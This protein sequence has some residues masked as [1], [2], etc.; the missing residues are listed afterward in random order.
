MHCSAQNKHTNMFSATQQVPEQRDT[1]ERS[2]SSF[3]A[4]QTRRLGRRQS[5]PL[6]SG[7]QRHSQVSKY[8]GQKQK[9]TPVQLSATR[10]VSGRPVT[11]YRPH[12]AR[13]SLPLRNH[14][15]LDHR[16]SAPGYAYCLTRA[17]FLTRGDGQAA[18]MATRQHP[19]P[20]V[21]QFKTP[22]DTVV[23]RGCG[24]ENCRCSIPACRRTRLDAAIAS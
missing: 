15:T 21:A 3:V 7:P 16:S 12:R 11:T 18:C 14:G 22:R 2:S 24:A 6:R 1:A 23:S 4:I 10:R 5:P 8:K 9:T 13:E 17:T 19:W 20:Q